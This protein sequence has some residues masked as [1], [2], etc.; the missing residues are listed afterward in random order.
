MMPLPVSTLSAIDRLSADITKAP[1]SE[2]SVTSLDD[3]AAHL[4]IN[5]AAASENVKINS[6]NALSQ[7]AMSPEEIIRLQQ[8]VSTYSID[9]SLISAVARKTVGAVETLLRS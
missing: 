8:V 2:N 7:G 3:R 1:L 4:F 9:I 6:L 5:A